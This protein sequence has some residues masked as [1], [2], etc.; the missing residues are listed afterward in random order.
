[1]AYN[2]IRGTDGDDTLVGSDFY[3]QI[4]G[5]EGNDLLFG[6]AKADDMSG[7]MGDDTLFG[8]N[9]KDRLLGR[10]GQDSLY[11]GMGADQLFGGEGDDVL[12]FTPGDYLGGGRGFDFIVPDTTFAQNGSLS[13]NFDSIEGLDLSMLQNP[14]VTVNE[15]GDLTVRDDAGV[16]LFI[17]DGALIDEIVG[18]NGVII[19]TESFGLADQLLL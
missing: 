3:D 1:M 6:N 14:T 18:P 13:G 8:G 9:G 17:D 2:K 10:D 7:G 15:F 16:F 4:L 12:F 19:P 5:G 11:G